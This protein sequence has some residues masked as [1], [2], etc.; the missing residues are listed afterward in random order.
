MQSYLGIVWAP[1]QAP[2]EV[3][4]VIHG[5]FLNISRGTGFAECTQC[6]GSCNARKSRMWC[7][8][9]IRRR[10]LEH[11]IAIHCTNSLMSVTTGVLFIWDDFEFPKDVQT[12][13]QVVYYPLL[14]SLQWH[15]SR[16]TDKGLICSVVSEV[17][18]E[19]PREL[20]LPFYC[21]STMCCGLLCPSWSEPKWRTSQWSG[22]C[23]GCI[24]ALVHV[25]CQVD[26]T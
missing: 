22:W 24:S 7:E 5:P 4:D 18:T 15:H 13:W 9:S 20:H 8:A 2:D 23:G 12:H 25:N 19:R 14:L 21:C 16:W 3:M 10:H 1:W 6:M 11:R 17:L 26:T